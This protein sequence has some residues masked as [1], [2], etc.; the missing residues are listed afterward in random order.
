MQIA[1]CDESVQSS[2]CDSYAVTRGH[3]IIFFESSLIFLSALRVT[4]Y[5]K[6]NWKEKRAY[7]ISETRNNCCELNDRLQ[8]IL[9]IVFDDR[10]MAE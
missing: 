3:L 10:F 9:H 8:A 5:S 4:K 1:S 6:R 2:Y 7:Y